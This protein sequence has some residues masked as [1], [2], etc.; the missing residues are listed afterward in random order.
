MSDQQIQDIIAAAC[1]SPCPEGEP[2][3][4]GDSLVVTKEP[5]GPSPELLCLHEINA[6][7]AQH[8]CYLLPRLIIQGGEALT[9]D[10]QVLRKGE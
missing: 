2:C 3:K 8:G 6:A 5:E 1:P 9:H 4:P 7:L 10:I